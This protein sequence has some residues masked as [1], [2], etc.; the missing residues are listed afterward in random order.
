MIKLIFKTVAFIGVIGLASCG[1]G[2]SEEH[3]PAEL[4]NNA[5][6][7][8]S[9]K[10]DERLPKMVFENPNQEFG[11][12][13]QG[14]SVTKVYKFTN[15]GDADLIISFAKGSCG[16]TIPTW[17]KRPIKPGET[18]EIEVIFNSQGKSNAQNKKVYITANTKPANNVISLKGNVIAP[19]NK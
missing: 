2:S 3:L 19:E 16:C 5:V 6:T 18:G 14:T 12:I 8:S 1:G 4:V 7:A 13:V 10:T 11:E 17:P 15:K 9:Q